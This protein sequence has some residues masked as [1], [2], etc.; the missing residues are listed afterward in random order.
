M[1]PITELIDVLT[2]TQSLRPQIDAAGQALVDSLKSGGKILTCG[3]GGSAADALHLSQELIGCYQGHRRPLPAVCLCAD[4]TALTCICNDFGYEQI[5]SR[6]VTALARPGDILVGFTT[7]G[8][9]SN[10]LAAFDAAKAAGIRTILVGGKDGGK[11]RGRCD[12]EVIIPSAST[13]RIQE[14]HTVVIHCWLDQVE[15]QFNPAATC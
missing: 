9:S 14:V 3:N 6:Q 5:F 1:N 7:S 8:N 11:A 4:A 12:L 13:A 15:K 10:V 2:R